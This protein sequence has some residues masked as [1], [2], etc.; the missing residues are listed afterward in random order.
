MGGGAPNAHWK[1]ATERVALRPSSFH[2]LSERKDVTCPCLRLLPI[3]QVSIGAFEFRVLMCRCG[4][5]PECV[6]V[7]REFVCACR[8]VC[9]LTL[10]ANS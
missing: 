10:A 1:F 2:L 4:G 9:V 8:D 3:F 5:V 7:V 6:L